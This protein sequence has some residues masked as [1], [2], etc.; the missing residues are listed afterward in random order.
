MEIIPA[1]L[2]KS[3]RGVTNKLESVAGLVR[4]AQLD[5]CDGVFVPSYTW[6]YNGP[7]TADKIPYEENFLPIIAD[8]NATMPFWEDFDFELD[9]MIADAPRLLPD[10]LRMGP[11]R[12][13]FHAE[14]FKNLESEIEQ[15]RKSVPGLIEM[16][17]AINADTDPS[18]IFPLIDAGL[19]T[20][21]QCMG[22]AKIGF[23]GQPFD[24]RVLANLKTLRA[25][26]PDLPLSVDGSVTLETA[27]RLIAA[28]ATR[29][30]SGSGLLS[31]PDIEERISEFK[32]I[33]I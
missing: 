5:I 25:K 29:L 3:F 17:M 14:A 32:S 31:A 10:L 8:E 33:M 20:S 6:P 13:I 4:T 16:A 30:A 19:I 24:E 22:I 26:Y 12:I 7:V 23:Q 1:I 28:G 27:P 15:L 9:L 21:V 2:E 18:I 11:T